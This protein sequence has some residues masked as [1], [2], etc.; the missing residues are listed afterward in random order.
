[1]LDFKTDSTERSMRKGYEYAGDEVK[2]LTSFS[3]SVRKIALA[4]KKAPRIFIF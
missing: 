2:D 1:M 4:N 3:K